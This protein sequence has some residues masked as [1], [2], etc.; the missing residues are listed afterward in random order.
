ML[1]VSLAVVAP[2]LTENALSLSFS[3][4]VVDFEYLYQ[5]EKQAS[6]TKSNNVKIAETNIHPGP[7]IAISAAIR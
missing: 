6:I 3:L 2:L 5:K 7:T 4:S 1:L